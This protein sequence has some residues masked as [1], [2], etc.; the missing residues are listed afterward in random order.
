MSHRASKLE[1]AIRKAMLLLAIL[2]I[3]NTGPTTA[4]GCPTCKNGLFGNQ[5]FAFAVSIVFM[6]S[7]PFVILGGWT[8]TIWRLRLDLVNAQANA[9]HASDSSQESMA[10]QSPSNAAT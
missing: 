2:W 6:M 1:S 4:I 9:A 8:I 7:V 10:C 3:L 5:G